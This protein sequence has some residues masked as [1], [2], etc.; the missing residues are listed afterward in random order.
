M[1]PESLETLAGC[2]V[3]L[4]RIDAATFRGST[5][6]SACE[7][8]FGKAAYATSEVTITASGIR[9][10]GPR[11]RREGEQVWGATKGGYEFVKL[12]SLGAAG[13]RRPPRSAAAPL[14]ADARE[15]AL[16]V[17]AVAGL[18]YAWSAVQR[19]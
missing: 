5:L 11:L 7:N 3:V 4:R 18:P 8:P 1:T 2:T 12:R 6:G 17:A 14:R 10:L 13:P 19:S 9:S 16:E 15:G